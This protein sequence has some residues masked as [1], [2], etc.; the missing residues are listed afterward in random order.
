MITDVYTVSFADLKR[1][2]GSK[3]QKVLAAILDECGDM[4]RDADGYLDKGA[5]VTCAD[6]L[7]DLINGVDFGASSPPYLYRYRCALEAVWAY[8]GEYLGQVWV[9]GCREVDDA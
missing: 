6:A 8:L 1:T 3:D 4:L 9:E 5:A 7:A 2:V